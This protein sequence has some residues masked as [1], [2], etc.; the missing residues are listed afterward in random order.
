MELEQLDLLLWKEEQRYVTL[1]IYIHNIF[2]NIS[3]NLCIYVCVCVGI[4]MYICH[5]CPV[6][7]GSHSPEAETTE[8]CEPPTWVLGHLT[9]QQAFLAKEPSLPYH[10]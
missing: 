7:C 10:I 9:E 1:N 6:F 5:M 3:L 8:D 4:Y 2:D